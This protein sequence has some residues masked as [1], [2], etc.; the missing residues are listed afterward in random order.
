MHELWF[1]NKPKQRHLN[2]VFE[3]LMIIIYIKCT[4]SNILCGKSFGFKA[5]GCTRTG[6]LH[7][8]VIYSKQLMMR[9]RLGSARNPYMMRLETSPSSQTLSILNSWTNI[10]PSYDKIFIKLF[11]IQIPK[12][13]L[14]SWWVL[15][16]SVLLI[17]WPKVQSGRSC[18]SL[19]PT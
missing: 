4:V 5:L 8:W 7:I 15:Q 10:H 13:I 14:G 16:S 6:N 11:E 1:R 17:I 19:G 9:S 12:L 2:P 3:K 18:V